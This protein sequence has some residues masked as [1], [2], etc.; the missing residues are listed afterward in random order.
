M[1]R[2]IYS[3]A[4]EHKI[5]QRIMC[6]PCKEKSGLANSER[7][8]IL[9]SVSIFEEYFYIVHVTGARTVK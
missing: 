6:F 7:H 9:F 3:F 1:F 4:K 2:L 8:F 5:S